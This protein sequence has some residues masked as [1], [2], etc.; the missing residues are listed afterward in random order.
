MDYNAIK[1]ANKFIDLAIKANQ[2]ITQINVL[3]FLYFANAAYL[4]LYQ[5]KLIKENFYAWKFGPV[6]P[7][8]YEITKKYGS[9]PIKSP[10]DELDTSLEKDEK[11]I[12]CIEIIYETFK[13][14]SPFQLV[15]ITHRKGGAW[16]ITNN[17]EY[18]GLIKESDIITEYENIITKI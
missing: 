8:V 13:D 16:D 18:R 3:K 5:Q 2:P 12:K 10:T 17:R 6:I 4:V 9:S 11:A 14:K 1:I 15:A 7:E